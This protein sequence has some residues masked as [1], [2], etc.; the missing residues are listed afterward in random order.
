MTEAAAFRCGTG[1]EKTIV[2]G[3]RLTVSSGLSVYHD[4]GTNDNLKV[5]VKHYR[6]IL[7]TKCPARTVKDCNGRYSRMAS[8]AA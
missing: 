2:Q 6:I 8:G 5:K 4:V 3:I 1:R 7:L